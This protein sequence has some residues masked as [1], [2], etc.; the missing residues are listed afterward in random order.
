MKKRKSE[1]RALGHTK[2]EDLRM[3]R[4]QQRFLEGMIIEVGGRKRTRTTNIKVMFRS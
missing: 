3:W 1:D 2:I 4:I